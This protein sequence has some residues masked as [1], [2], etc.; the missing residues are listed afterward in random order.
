[1]IPEPG[2]QKDH[3]KR[4]GARGGRPVTHDKN[5]Y[6]GRNVIERA[7]NG[8]KNW[9]GL[10]TRYAVIYRAG[11]ILAASLIWLA[12]LEEHVL[13]VHQAATGESASPW[14]SVTGQ[15]SMVCHASLR[16]RPWWQPRARDLRRVSG[17]CVSS[18]QSD[19]FPATEVTF[20]RPL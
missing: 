15:S 17:S 9:R 3:R 18:L 8:F 12:D 1:V 7:F 13:G 20:R 16:H 5:A 2:D 10:A 6:R 4:R 14:G 11:L 19:T